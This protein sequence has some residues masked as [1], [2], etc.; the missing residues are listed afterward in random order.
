MKNVLLSVQVKLAPTNFAIKLLMLI[1]TMLLSFNND[2][3]A[4]GHK[5]GVKTKPAAALPT[6][7]YTGPKTYTAG[8]AIAPLAPTSSGVLAAAY[9]SGSVSFATGFTNPRS[10]ARDAQGNV[11]VADYGTSTVIKIP[12]GGGA[13][14]TIGS[15]FSG[16]AG[17]AVDGFGNVFV[18]DVGSSSIKEV[19]VHTNTITTLANGFSNPL[20]IAADAQGNV[21]IADYPNAEVKKIPVGGGSAVIIGGSA[22]FQGP[23]GVAVDAAGNVYVT[24]A[25]G[26]SVKE[27]PAAGGAIVT[28]ASGLNTPYG[29]TVDPSGNL[30]IADGGSGTI[31]EIPAGGSSPIVVSSVFNTPVGVITDASGNLL[32][33][34]YGNTAIQTIIP[35]GGYYIN[36]ALPAG[37][38]FNNNTGVISGQPQVASLAT[39]YTVTAYNASG[40]VPATVSI[41]VILPAPPAVS[42]GSAKTYTSGTAITNLVPTAS[43][44]GAAAYSNVPETIASGFQN[45]VGLSLD[46]NDNLYTADFNTGIIYE[47]LD[48]TNTPVALASGFGSAFGVAADEAGDVYVTDRDNNTLSLIPAGGG[49]ITT[50]GSGYNRPEGITVDQAGNIYLADNGDNKIKK[51]YAGTNTAVVFNSFAQSPLG[52]TTDPTGNVF[53]SAIDGGIYPLEEIPAAG[54]KAAVIATGFFDPQFI[55]SDLAGNIYVADELH[56]AIKKTAANSTSSAIIGS[57]VLFPTGIAIDEAGNLFVTEGGTHTIKKLTPVGGYFITPALPKGLIFDSNTGIIS[58]TALAPAAASDY[59]I[60]AYNAGGFTAA[61]VNIKVVAPAAPIISYAGPDTYSA[62]TAI[63]PLAPVSAR[64]GAQAYSNSLVTLATGFNSPGGV[65]RDAAGNVY[66]TDII[67]DAVKKIPAGG[68]PVT[69]IGTGFALPLAL[70]ADAAGNVFVTDGINNTVTEIPAA[71]GAAVH[72]GSGYS[73]PNGIALDAAGN[74]YVSNSMSGHIN[75]IPAGTTTPIVIGTGFSDPLSIAVDA[76]GNVYVGDVITGG[77]A[78]KK[79]PAAGGAPVIIATGM[80]SPAALTIDA[81]GNIYAADANDNAIYRVPA[82]GGTPV[83]LGSGVIRPEGIVI[84]PTGNLYVSDY[85]TNAVEKIVPTGGYFITPVLPAGLAFNSAT[86]V[87][88]GTPTAASAAANY[89]INAYNSG[90]SGA[91]TVNIQVVL[92]SNANLSGLVASVGTLSPAFTGATT[93]YTASVANSAASITVTPTT[94]DAGASV[95]VN[96]ITVVSGTASGAIALAVGPN[97][98]T[99]VVTAADGTTI[100]TY[101][102]TVTR[103]ASANA[104]L[105]S[106]G[107]SVTP[108]SP[109]FAATTLSYTL[110]APNATSSMT[111]KPVTSDPGA[112]I[113]VNG[114]TVVSGTMSGPIALAE[115]TQTIIS[116][117]VTAADGT[118]TK[119]YTLTV[120]RAASANDNLSALTLSAGTLSPAFAGGTLNYTASVANSTS[121]ITITPTAADINATIKVNGTTVSSGTASGAIALSVGPNAISVAVTAQNGAATATYTVTVTRV[122]SANANLASMNPSVTPLSPSFAPG[123]TSYTLNVSGSVSS[124]TVRPVTSDVNATLKV[125]GTTLASGTVSP[126]I[127]LAVGPNTI[128]VAVTAQDGTTIKTYTITATRAAGGANSFASAIGVTKPTETIAVAEDGILI[129][130]GISP[131]GDGINDFLQI[132]NIGQYPENKLSIMNRSGQMIYEAK[133]YDNSS[134]VFDGHSNKNG[135]LQLPGT[136]F[137]QLDYTVNGVTKHKTGFVVLKY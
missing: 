48:G 11:Y 134:K 115:G 30:F 62:G 21:Y 97:T 14:T 10:I 137:F 60:T 59:L 104:N 42:Y 50:V 107:P 74:I 122:A 124:M 117:V 28:L 81:A 46:A 84:D 113:K 22:D 108:L 110:S 67:N 58:G 130:Q 1:G 23:S 126:P 133:N 47:V 129:H 75:K 88:S 102:L 90:G 19:A 39:N 44:V 111:V 87:I 17:V 3:E 20:G 29:L 109:T 8:T 93:S 99:I 13:N 105:A 70:A 95:K 65:G 53:F 112:S 101:T 49:D 32:V 68:G 33:A 114:T 127:A 125:N 24:D 26:N 85:G 73:R 103:V 43:R 83:A 63:T 38:S 37:L 128:T 56:S 35:L 64:V 116:I 86:G 77:T 79:I 51:I 106:I 5:P 132:D 4:G 52:V 15:G 89:I 91:A 71:G 2:V 54:G 25:T 94:S 121:S 76:F 7:S 31:K 12:V 120:N 100:K 82:G 16:L 45:P 80:S 34:D 18:L 136:Y 27:I 57:G 69:T 119:T 9:N 135:R 36:K 6:L 92:S 41:R 118:S 123:T 96:G 78:I 61:I 72:I 66:V 98:I 40:S 131:N 55:T